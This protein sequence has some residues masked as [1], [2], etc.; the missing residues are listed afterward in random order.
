MTTTARPAR[1]VPPGRGTALGQRVVVGGG[2][3]GTM[4][5]GS[6]A[7]LSDFDGYDGRNEIPSVTRP[8]IAG[9]PEEFQLAQEQ[10]AD[11]Q[12]TFHAGATYFSA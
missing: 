1:P 3:M 8:G 7:A 9:L 5:P 11:A 10:P 4:L 6:G 2:P 12:I